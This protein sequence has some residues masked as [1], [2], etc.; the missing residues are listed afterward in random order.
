MKRG[1]SLH[2]A[3]P[4]WWRQTKRSWA[5]PGGLIAAS[6]T[7]VPRLEGLPPRLRTFPLLGGTLGVHQAFWRIPFPR[8]TS[9]I[10]RYFG[11]EVLGCRALR[12][13]SKSSAGLGMQPYLRAP[14]HVWPG[15]MYGT[16]CLSARAMD[17]GFPTVELRVRSGSGFAA[18]P[19]SP[20]RDGEV[21]ARFCVGV[22]AFRYE[23]CLSPDF[24]S[25]GLWLLRLGMGCGFGAA[26]SGRGPRRVCF[27]V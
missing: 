23:Y 25:W 18:T 20:A 11:S 10:A 13:E 15:H 17:T 3:R 27:G 16:G 6:V 26:I 7:N 14:G 21:R 8:H 24:R 22:R 2:P 9:G 19:R 4:D 5:T 1:G 12:L